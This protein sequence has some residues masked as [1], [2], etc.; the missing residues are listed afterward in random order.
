MYCFHN[1]VNKLLSDE[2]KVPE[3]GL[4]LFETS[5]IFFKDFTLNK[6]LDL[7]TTTPSLT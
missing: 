5:C 3:H 1:W 6:G 4:K 2:N 7:S